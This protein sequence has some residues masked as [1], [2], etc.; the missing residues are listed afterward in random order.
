MIKDAAKHLEVKPEL[1]EKMLNEGATTEK[2]LRNYCIKKE[3]ETRVRQGSSEN[4]AI[5]TIE[6]EE[7]YGKVSEST[8][9]RAVKK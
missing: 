6:I 7:T 4:S 2:N 3:V 1:V 8:I 9:R 5:V